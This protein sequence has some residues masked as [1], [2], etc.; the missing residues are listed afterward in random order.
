M[1]NS[2]TIKPQEAFET[3]VY[4]SAMREQAELQ[5]AYHHKCQQLD[6]L[7]ADFKAA[8]KSLDTSQ[9]ALKKLKYEN[10]KL[11]QESSTNENKKMMKRVTSEV[12][13]LESYHLSLADYVTQKAGKSRELTSV[14]AQL[15]ESIKVVREICS[16]STHNVS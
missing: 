4:A 7:A 1:L 14:M 2:S 5:Q 16:E 13:V 8:S 12:D 11:F 9:A 6:K 10:D 15:Q 3:K